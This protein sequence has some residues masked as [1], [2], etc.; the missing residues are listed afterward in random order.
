MEDS[1]NIKNSMLGLLKKNYSVIN[2]ED[3]TGFTINND[4]SEKI[5]DD[6]L[7]VKDSIKLAGTFTPKIAGKRK[8]ITTLKFKEGQAIK[9][10]A[11]IEVIQVQ[12]SV[13]LERPKEFSKFALNSDQKIVFLITN[14]SGLD[15]TEIKIEQMA[16]PLLKDIVIKKE[17]LVNEA[18]ENVG[19][20]KDITSFNLDD[21]KLDTSERLYITGKLKTNEE[22]KKKLGI[23][24]KYKEAE[25]LEDSDD[26]LGAKFEQEI[27]IVG[28]TIVG[29]VDPKLP[30]KIKLGGSYEVTFIFTNESTE[31]PATGLKLEV[32]QE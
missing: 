18:Y 5:N 24:V 17:K 9:L 22:G 25:T 31:F 19:D 12:L 13:S 4:T 21:N 23:L 3:E 2:K 1:N 7:T 10:P 8:L 28:V 16:D 20:S 11:E 15:A 14:T 32:K 30:Q 26:K 27:T 6:T 29:K